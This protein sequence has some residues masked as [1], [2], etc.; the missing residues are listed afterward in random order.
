MSS[1]KS[2]PGHC[3]TDLLVHGFTDEGWSVANVTSLLASPL[4]TNLSQ[5]ITSW[6]HL[7]SWIFMNPFHSLSAFIFFSISFACCIH[8]NVSCS[9]MRNESI[10]PAARYLWMFSI[11]CIVLLIS[12]WTLG[13]LFLIALYWGLKTAALCKNS[14]Q[15]MLCY[16]DCNKTSFQVPQIQLVSP[17]SSCFPAFYLS[18]FFYTNYTVS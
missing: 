18:V 12:I 8:G 13:N 15:G 11:Y 14:Y 16:V 5:A 2:A 9:K 4:M 3:V 7:T 17:S 10:F 1:F 6:Q